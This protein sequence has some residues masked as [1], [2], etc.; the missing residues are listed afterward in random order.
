MIF[1]IG[2]DIPYQCH[3]LE[4]AFTG[5]TYKLLLIY[6]IILGVY[7]YLSFQIKLHLLSTDLHDGFQNS[8]GTLKS[9]E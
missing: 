3:K 4:K 9:T 7:E 1:V 2:H 8:L 6:M 5:P